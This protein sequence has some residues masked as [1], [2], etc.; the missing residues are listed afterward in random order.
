MFN[1][2]FRDSYLLLP[3]SLAKLAKNFKVE[4]KGIFPYEY[5]KVKGLK[6]PIYFSEL[7]PLL[8]KDQRIEINQEK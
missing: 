8:Y 7:K 2:Y 6:N 1:L 4:N 3:S 5:V